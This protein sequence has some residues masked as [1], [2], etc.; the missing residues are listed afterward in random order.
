[1]KVEKLFNNS[2][3]AKDL[4]EQKQGVLLM[5]EIPKHLNPKLPPIEII[6]KD[7]SNQGIEEDWTK[8]FYHIFKDGNLLNLPRLFYGRKS[9]STKELHM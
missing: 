4:I 6:K 8:I 3:K 7:D 2:Q 1:M 5:F 9:W